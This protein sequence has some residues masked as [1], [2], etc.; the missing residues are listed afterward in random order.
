[1]RLVTT[2]YGLMSTGRL[3]QDR[4]I[5]HLAKNSYHQ[6]KHTP[7]LFTHESNGVAFSLV[8]D[9][10]LVKYKIQESADHLTATL[11]SLYT[12]T[13]E[14]ALKQKYVGFTIDY[15]MKLTNTLTRFGKL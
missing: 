10:F 15:D 2:V 11:R 12:I 4:L 7:G 8:V 13:V 5:A 14:T 1:M 3:S 6:A 9:D